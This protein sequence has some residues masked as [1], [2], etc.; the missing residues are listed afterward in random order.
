M[1]SAAT[2]PTKPAAPGTRIQSVERGC[3]LL[4]WFAERS[5]GATAKEAAFANCLALPTTYHLLNTL[6][7]QGFLAKDSNRRYL[8]GRSSAA[9]AR[10]Y[11]RGSVVPE[12]LLTALRAVAERTSETAYLVDWGE[13]DIRVIASV[14]GR[15]VVRVA[16]VAAGAYEGAHARAN[17]KVLLAHAS[18]EA[19]DSYLR[20]HPLE[21]RAR[22]TICELDRLEAELASIRERGHACD[23][24]EFSEGV[25]CIAAPI[26]RDGA[27]IAAL[28]LSVPADRFARARQDLTRDLLAVIDEIE[29]DAGPAGSEAQLQ[30][31]GIR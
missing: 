3:R 6:V 29:M 25:S 19:L 27:V 26:V 12:G 13:S 1:N 4:L 22:G 17:G 2:Q 5:E 30:E 15:N 11:L 7:D 20:R 28:G 18:P 16:E 14:E 23:L 9:L 8:L 10:A 31:V 21:R 24:E